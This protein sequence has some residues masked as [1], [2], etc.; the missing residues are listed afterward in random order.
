[1]KE[2]ECA[3]FK[4]LAVSLIIPTHQI[5]IPEGGEKCESTTFSVGLDPFMLFRD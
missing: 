4:V 2:G 5:D 1:M 3:I